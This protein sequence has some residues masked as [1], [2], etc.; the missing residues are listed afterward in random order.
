MRRLMVVLALMAAMAVGGQEKSD[1][2]FTG[3]GWR[4]WPSAFHGAYMGVIGAAI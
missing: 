3:Q 1:Y 2:F 4:E